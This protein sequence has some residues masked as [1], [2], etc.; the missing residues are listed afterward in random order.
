[1]T[2]QVTLQLHFITIDYNRAFGS[3]ECLAAIRNSHTL[4]EERKREAW[5]KM[6]RKH[7]PLHRERV[8][9][10]DEEAEEGWSL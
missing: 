7:F 4:Y 2:S 3:C 5:L 6:V 1:M 10:E 8:A 9:Q